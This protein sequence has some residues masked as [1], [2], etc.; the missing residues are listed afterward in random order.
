[1][2][3]D[4]GNTDPRRKDPRR[5]G[6]LIEDLSHRPGWSERLAL[7]KLAARWAEIVGATVAARCEPVKLVDGELFVRAE[8][9]TWATELTL[10]SA[11]LLE[12]VAGVLPP[13]SVTRVRAVVGRARQE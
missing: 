1:M 10:L 3:R 4:D 7:G 13:G 5:L 2:R 12:R 6:E 11:T 9:P 8:N